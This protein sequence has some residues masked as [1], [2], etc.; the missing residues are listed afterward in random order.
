M[1]DPKLL[2]AKMQPISTTHSPRPRHGHPQ[3]ISL[4]Q[5]NNIFEYVNVMVLENAKII[6][7]Q[8]GGNRHIVNPPR[9]RDTA[10]VYPVEQQRPPFR[11]G[12]RHGRP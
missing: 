10:K 4:E 11:R 9:T 8:H 3:R 7:H 5:L 6:L 12:L 2:A 1:I